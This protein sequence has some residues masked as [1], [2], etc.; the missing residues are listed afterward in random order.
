M[1]R[2]E[3]N[4]YKQARIANQEEDADLLAEFE[5]WLSRKK[6]AH[7]AVQRHRQDVAPFVNA[8]RLLK[9]AATASPAARRLARFMG[10]WF[11]HQAS[12]TD[13]A[14]IKDLAASLKQFSAFLEEKGEIGADVRNDLGQT[15]K[16]A[17]NQ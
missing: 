4:R 2:E 7:A 12:S 15:I 10:C 8:V 1:L 5:V 17:W 14:S 3:F 16:E 9:E 6:V 13:P 11:L